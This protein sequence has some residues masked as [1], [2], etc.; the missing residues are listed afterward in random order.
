[1]T[2]PIELGL[3]PY[4]IAPRFTYDQDW[5]VAIEPIEGSVSPVYPPGTT[6]VAKIYVD[7]K[8]STLQQPPVT[9]W[10]GV[11]VDDVIR[12]RV[13][14]ALTDVIP[15]GYWMRICLKYPN[16]PD[17]DDYVLGKGKVVRDD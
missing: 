6:V 17:T 11:I 5:I 10:P 16:T 9:S 15:K 7:N 13:E 14:S 4:D 1:M 2:T 3:D 8:L 12:F